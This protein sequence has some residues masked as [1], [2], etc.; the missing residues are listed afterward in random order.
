MKCVAGTALSKAK[1]I[2]LDIP[3]EKLHEIQKE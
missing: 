1:D 3:A 2:K